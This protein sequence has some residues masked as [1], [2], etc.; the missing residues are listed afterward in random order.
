LVAITNS[1]RIL[2]IGTFTG[3]ATQCLVEGVMR[4]YCSIKEIAII[5]IAI[6]VIVILTTTIVV[7]VVMMNK[8]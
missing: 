1:T 3:Y 7:V 8:S 2:E 5:I 6:I 4:Y